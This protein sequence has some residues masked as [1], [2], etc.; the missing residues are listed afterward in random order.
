MK[1]DIVGSVASGKTT[2][3]K[4]ISIKYQ[5]PHFKKVILYGKELLME[6]R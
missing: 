6:T 5:I 1:I 4:N 2:L 3:A